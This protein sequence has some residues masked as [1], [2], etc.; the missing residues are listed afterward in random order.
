MPEISHH[1]FLKWVSL[2]FLFPKQNIHPWIT[3]LIPMLETILISSHWCNMIRFAIWM[4]STSSTH[5]GMC[6]W[7]RHSVVKRR[8][9]IP[10]H[11]SSAFYSFLVICEGVR[12]FSEVMLASAL[13]TS[14]HRA[15]HFS[16]CWN[17]CIPKEVRGRFPSLVSIYA[18]FT[19]KMIR[20]SRNVGA[21]DAMF[22]LVMLRTTNHK[23][24]SWT[25]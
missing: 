5:Q 21:E 16:Y 8:I 22:L 9:E 3:L 25:I 15:S 10:N 17:F 4:L 6:I 14:Y 2:S 1:I 18:F 20:S 13:L 23:V 11:L 24:K 12:H 7:Q 19:H